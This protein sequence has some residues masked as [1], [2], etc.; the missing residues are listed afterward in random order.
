M[1]NSAMGITISRILY[2]I[3][4]EILTEVFRAR[5]YTEA[6]LPLEAMII[7]KVIRTRVIPDINVFGGKTSKVVLRPEYLEDLK[8]NAADDYTRTGP[9]S[10]YRIPP[11]ERENCAIVDIHHLTYAG[12]Y[13]GHYPNATGWQGG[14]N[15]PALGQ[16]VLDS[17]T[18]A[19]TPPRPLAEL[20]S[21][22]LVKLTP[23]QHAA[24][25]WVMECRIGYDEN[26]TNMSSSS[27]EPFA[28]LCVAAVKA[29]IYNNSIIRINKAYVESGYALDEWKNI[30]DGYRESEQRYLELMEVMAGASVLSPDRL[31][32]MMRYMM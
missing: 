19:S 24:V 28:N 27:V 3:P 20:L 14:T 12:N 25:N 18:F 8:F 29:Y 1:M 32:T 7:N 17:H 30:V 15:V 11:D 6:T 21:G 5:D 10:L 22:D 2:S 23:S 9:F 26:V 16:A 4:R 31:M 13:A